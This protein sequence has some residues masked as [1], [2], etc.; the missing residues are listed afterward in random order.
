MIE[1]L[2]G[3]H[4]TV[5]YKEH[6]NIRLHDNTDFE[7]YPTHWHTPI[8]IILPLENEYVVES[9]GEIYTVK[10]GEILMICPGVLH[11]LYASKGRRLILQAEVDSVIHIKQLESILSLLSP[12]VY[13]TPENAPAIYHHVH[14]LFLQI[15]DEYVQSH[16]L[17]EASI[18]AKLLDMLVTIG[19]HHTDNISSFGV[20]HLKQK[21]YVDTFMQICN[22]IIAH[23]TEDLSLEDIA[24]QSGF[25]KYHFSRLFKQ[26]ANVTFYKYLNQKRIALAE[27]LLID[28][29]ISVT[30]V[31]MQCG[32]SSLSSFIRMFK[33]IKGCTP[34]EFRAMYN[35]PPLPKVPGTMITAENVDVDII[36]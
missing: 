16:A 27:Q 17:C 13:L 36:Q 21:E 5:V 29:T 33:I 24:S 32:F 8:E 30:N 15:I 6:T 2:N 34:S 22:Y 18:Y 20:S 4:E 7:E 31:S 14:S 10:E 11:R 3:V 1:K 23:C 19:K 12:I 28:P 26:F 9:D 25:S 35:V